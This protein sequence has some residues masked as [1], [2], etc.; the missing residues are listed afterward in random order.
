MKR[1]QEKRNF[2][3]DAA[4]QQPHENQESG[5]LHF[6]IALQP[7]IELAVRVRF[8]DESKDAFIMCGCPACNPRKPT[9][10]DRLRQ[11]ADIL[12]YEQGLAR[13]EARRNEHPPNAYTRQETK[14]CVF[15]KSCGLPN[16]LI[17]Y[18]NPSGFIPVEL[19]TQYGAFAVLGSGSASMPMAWIGGSS[20]ATALTRCL[21]GTLATA[22]AE[23]DVLAVV[24]LSDT[25]S[26]DRAL[27]TL[28]QYTTLTSAKTRTRLHVERLPDNS[29]RAYGFYTGKNKDWENVPVVAATADGERFIVD[30]GQGIQLIWTPGATT[31]MPVLKDAS[32]LP[33]VWVYPPTET[34]NKFLG[35]PVHPPTYQDMVVWFPKTDIPPFYISFCIP[36]TCPHPDMMEEL[37]SYI[38]GEMNRNIHDPA[39]LEM[40]RLIDYDPVVEEQK[41]AELPP[42]VRMDGPLNH[43]VIAMTNKATAAVIWTKKVGQDREWDHKPKLRAMYNN[44]V[45]HKQGKHDYYY[46]IWSNIHYGYVGIIAGLSESVLLDGAGAE[47]IAS[48]T[49]RKL[50]EWR[51]KP[52]A[53][54]KLPGPHTTASPWTSLRS[55]DDVADRVSISIGIKIADQHPTG[56]VTAKMIM[57]EVLAVAP[58]DWGDGIEIHKCK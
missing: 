3:A 9:L 56:G 22:P 19:L 32:P 39:V 24:L 29:V 41:F 21:G 55:W 27:Y 5:V 38:A 25:A 15:A 14:G 4:S 23:L 42:L 44:V 54:W 18:S 43:S 52:K 53:D 37:A 17:N 34:A 7:T 45:W 50:D 36:K 8:F 1:V 47:Q 30:L 58:E 49:Y 33:P 40:R 20:S 16:G 57:A 26:S 11:E 48:D 46:D 10:A 2:P 51:N 31:K 12:R 35:N 6:G 28:D 13:D